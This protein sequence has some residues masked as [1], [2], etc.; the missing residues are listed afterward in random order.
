MDIQSLIDNFLTIEDNSYKYT[1]TYIYTRTYINKNIQLLRNLRISNEGATVVYLYETIISN[2]DTIRGT[3]EIESVY[4]QLIG[5]SDI[6]ISD[7]NHTHIV[8]LY[9]QLDEYLKEIDDILHDSDLIKNDITPNGDIVLSQEH[10]NFYIRKIQYFQFIMQ[11]LLLKYIY[12]SSNIKEGSHGSIEYIYIK[13]G[14]TNGMTC[15]SIQNVHSIHNTFYYIYCREL[16]SLESDINSIHL[17]TLNETFKNLN[18]ILYMLSDYIDNISIITQTK[19]LRLPYLNAFILDE[20]TRLDILPIICQITST[21]TSTSTQTITI[22][23]NIHAIHT[24]L[25]EDVINVINGNVIFPEQYYDLSRII[26]R[27]NFERFLLDVGYYSDFISFMHSRGL[28]NGSINIDNSKNIVHGPANCYFNF[29]YNSKHYTIS[30]HSNLK[31]SQQSLPGFKF[32]IKCIDNLNPIRL[33]IQFIRN[34]REL[35]DPTRYIQ[36]YYDG[37]IYFHNDTP[38]P[39][40]ADIDIDYYHIIKGF[41][42]AINQ[43]WHNTSTISDQYGT[44]FLGSSFGGGDYEELYKYKYLK[45]KY[46]YIQLK[47]NQ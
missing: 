46:K 21:Q 26:I 9:N 3:I 25:S 16:Y 35:T 36:L 24:K 47:N 10:F 22:D 34:T 28:V 41:E 8:T 44:Y 38:I 11:K 4:D 29:Q 18:Y 31:D 43:L 37:Y 33:S 7:T 40:I 14:T 32:H 45:Y 1:H 6:I 15:I 12:I 27:E 17:H 5:Q 19:C 30:F 13:R 39:N 2:I 23:D 20:F 42:Y